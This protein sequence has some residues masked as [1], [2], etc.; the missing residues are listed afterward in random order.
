MTHGTS[1]TIACALGWVVAHFLYQFTFG[2]GDY[3]I[4]L[5]RSFFSLAV[6]AGVWWLVRGEFKPDYREIVKAKQA[7]E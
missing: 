2:G 6:I 5:D 4:A 1:K 7:A 3:A